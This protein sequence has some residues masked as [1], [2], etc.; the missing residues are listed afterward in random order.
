LDRDFGIEQEQ[1]RRRDRVIIG[2]FDFW[3][4]ASKWEKFIFKIFLRYDIWY[5]LKFNNKS[6]FYG[7]TVTLTWENMIDYY[8]TLLKQLN[9]TVLSQYFKQKYYSSMNKEL[10]DRVESWTEE[11]V[12]FVFNLLV[13][14]RMKGGKTTFTRN[15]VWS[16]LSD[17]NHDHSPRF[18]FQLFDKAI[19]LERLENEE[20]PYDRSLI[21]PR[22]LIKALETVSR[23]AVDSLLEE[24]QELDSI[25]DQLKGRV[26]PFDIDMLKGS[27]KDLVKLAFEIGFIAPYDSNS[28][29][30]VLR[31]TVPDL[32]LKGLEM[33]RR[34]H[35]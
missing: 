26:V 12:I 8:K 21:R 11:Q 1:L 7:R 2:L 24:Y 25:S 28:S 31:V 35:A 4:L 30:E 6:H 14:E 34:G 32:Y 22:M 18:L 19:K 3:N 20:N 16:R 15:W 10:P 9:T 29:G 27:D 23:L 5:K 13:S 17:G 33:S